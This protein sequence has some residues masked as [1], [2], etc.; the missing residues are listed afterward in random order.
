M[1]TVGLSQRGCVVHLKPGESQTRPA[2]QSP[3]C[4]RQEVRLVSGREETVSGLGQ[5]GETSWKRLPALIQAFGLRRMWMTEE[6]TGR[7]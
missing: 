5:P 4:H 1:T 2:Q 6:G 3:D 7:V